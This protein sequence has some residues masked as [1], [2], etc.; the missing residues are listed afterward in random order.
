MHIQNANI[1]KI[2]SLFLDLIS[3]VVPNI[4]E[5]TNF[6]N[7]NLKTYVVLKISVE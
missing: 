1:T 4:S 6:P 3:I 2:L 7:E 5:R